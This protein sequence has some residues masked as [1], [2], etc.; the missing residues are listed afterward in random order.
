MDNQK[1]VYQQQKK[2]CN[3][4]GKIGHRFKQCNIP[5]ISV[6]IIAIECDKKYHN[7]I[8]NE[9]QKI[10]Q[11]YIEKNIAISPNICKLKNINYLL[12]CRRHT[13]GYIEFIRGNY[14]NYAEVEVLFSQMLQREVDK[15]L[16]YSF[17]LLWNDLWTPTINASNE[18]I[19]MPVASEVENKLTDN[20]NIPLIN[21]KN[22]SNKSTNKVN[23]KHTNKTSKSFTN[24]NYKKINNCETRKW[25][26]ET[27]KP[28]T[29]EDDK[30]IIHES[31]RLSMNDTNNTKRQDTYLLKARRTLFKKKDS[32]KSNNSD[33]I[34]K[35]K[36]KINLKNN[37]L[38]YQKS[39]EKFKQ[40]QHTNMLTKLVEKTIP[41]WT[42]CEWGFPKGRKNMY[43][44][45]FLHCAV[46]EFCE[47]TGL[48]KDD[49]YIFKQIRPLTENLIGTNGK[50]YV[51]KYF[52]AL[53]TKN[54]PLEIGLK[55]KKQMEEIGAISL[56]N[57][58]DTVKKIR[59]YHV[60]RINI[61]HNVHKYLESIVSSTLSAQ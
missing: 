4:C 38:E 55:N 51:H 40:L 43:N 15:I 14:G 54:E 6:G 57:Y 13:V 41:Q 8:T 23:K 31:R 25:M 20:L 34:L 46:R 5:I 42:E 18:K 26:S 35:N 45:S 48:K 2:F 3:N 21:K 27:G 37:F 33:K 39:K 12:I 59:P 52:L 61:I 56:F 29:T 7:T 17:D 28:S 9:L 49:I 53:I 10:T 36:E 19:E 11:F 16:K 60:N 50:S 58:E 44:E 22:N 24:D 32:E 1:Y 30:N 47:E